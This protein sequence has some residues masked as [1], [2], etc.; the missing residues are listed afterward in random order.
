MTAPDTNIERQRRRH[1]GPIV[2]IVL[3]LAVAVVAGFYFTGADP[4]ATDATTGATAA[5]VGIVTDDN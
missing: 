2:G 5:E 3:A 1:W 4:V